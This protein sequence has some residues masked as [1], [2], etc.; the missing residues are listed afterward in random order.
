MNRLWAVLAAFTGP[1]V[2]QA[3]VGRRVVAVV[4]IVAFAVAAASIA[5]SIYGVVFALAVH[6]VSLL[7]T[8][9]HVAR[10]P[11]RPF[12]RTLEAGIFWATLALTAAGVRGFF[13]ESAKFPSSSMVPTIAID[14]HVFISKRA[15]WSRGDI[16]MFD[17]PCMPAAFVKR[18]IALGGDTVEIRC[19]VLFVNGE[20]VPRE[21]LREETY[22]DRDGLGRANRDRDDRWLTRSAT[23]Y[24]E[25]L[26]G[27]RYDVFDT[28]EPVRDGDFPQ[29]M[30]PTC[31]FSGGGGEV[32][33]RCGPYRPFVVP[34]GHA[35]VLGDNRSNSN[36]SRHWGALPVGNIRGRVM[37]IWLPLDRFGPVH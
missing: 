13:A 26:G 24:R 16:V 12:T 7:D 22:Q 3:L 29:P 34:P 31:S 37:G 36:D 35:F 25:T 15:G 28:D 17:H 6:V 10:H 9:I 20:R 18:V 32:V 5:F 23:R 27:K 1:G 33:P 11:V 8:I 30:L 4:F 2:A 14:D 19:G 21:R